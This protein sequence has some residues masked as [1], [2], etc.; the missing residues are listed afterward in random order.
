LRCITGDVLEYK[1]RIDIKL[2]D[3]WPA[4]AE[5][6]PDAATLMGGAVPSTG[7]H[8]MSETVS[9]D[10]CLTAAHEFLYR[11]VHEQKVRHVKTVSLKNKKTTPAGGKIEA[12][13]LQIP[14]HA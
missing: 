10:E 4:C 6:G 2:F 9:P 8:L 5:L 3:K 12:R 13:R 14:G 11:F 1:S 7:Y